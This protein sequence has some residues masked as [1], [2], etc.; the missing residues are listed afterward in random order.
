MMLLKNKGNFEKKLE[1]FEKYWKNMEGCG[2][3]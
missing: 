3:V 1:V 2:R